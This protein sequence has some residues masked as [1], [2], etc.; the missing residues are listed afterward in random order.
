MAVGDASIIPADEAAKLEGVRWN[1]SPA[2]DVSLRVPKQGTLSD[3]MRKH[4]DF[5]NRISSD[6]FRPVP[7]LR[8]FDV[9]QY[10]SQFNTARRPFRL[11]ELRNLDG[12][13]FRYSHRKLIHIAGM[14]RHLAIEAMKTAGLPRGVASN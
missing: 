12:S 5:L 9:M 11:F 2:G 3:L 1:P 4:T 13:R 14:V 10:R 6:G 7:P 8:M